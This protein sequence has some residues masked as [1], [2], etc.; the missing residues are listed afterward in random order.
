MMHICTSRKKDS[1]IR[2]QYKM[3]DKDNEHVLE[4]VESE[5][6]LGVHVTDALNPSKQCAEAVLK[7]NKIICI[8]QRSLRHIKILF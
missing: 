3:G 6:D 5:K 1:I 7:A 8:I 4:T 2:Y